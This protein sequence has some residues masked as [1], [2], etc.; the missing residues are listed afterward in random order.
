MTVILFSK[1]GQITVRLTFL[2]IYLLCK[3]INLAAIFQVLEH[4]N[5]FEIIS[6]G[7]RFVFQNETKCFSQTKKIYMPGLFMVGLYILKP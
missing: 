7:E 4:F 5:D 1:L 2:A 6:Y 3:L